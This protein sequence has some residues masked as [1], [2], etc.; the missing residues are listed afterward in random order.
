MDSQD[1]S[2]RVLELPSEIGIQEAEA[3]RLELLALVASRAQIVVSCK[4]VQRVGT[5]GLQVLA[6]LA[7]TLRSNGASL[8]LR[9]PTTALVDAAR[10][11]GLQD[12]LGIA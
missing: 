2:N 6:S 8:S 9:E 3:L 5:A 1:S 10:G 11:L 12:L 4:E 7:K